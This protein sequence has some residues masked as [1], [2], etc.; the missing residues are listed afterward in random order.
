MDIM[1]I[2]SMPLPELERTVSQYPWF[3]FARLELCRKMSALGEEH[4]RECLKNAAPFMD[5]NRKIL[6]DC[7]RISVSGRQ[8]TGPSSRKQASA[9]AASIIISGGDYFSKAD[10]D[11]L[12][13]DGSTSAIERAGSMKIRNQAA[14]EIADDGVFDDPSFFTETLAGIYADQGLF[15][16]AYEV[17]D[18]L[19]LLYPEKSAYF[20]SL[21]NEMKKQL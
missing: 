17:Y 13:K 19:I 10:F 5:L 9:P 8:E 15:D 6:R 20:A 12:L 3:S 16:K 11:E 4:R 18:K 14:T 7:Y 21:K 2:S 1:E